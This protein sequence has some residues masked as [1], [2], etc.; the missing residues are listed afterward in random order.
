MAAHQQL[1]SFPAC[2]VVLKPAVP[3]AFHDFAPCPHPTLHALGPCSMQRLSR[4]FNAPA[5]ARTSCQQAATTSATI[6]I[7]H[8]HPTHPCPARAYLLPGSRTCRRRRHMVWAG[9]QTVL[10][11]APRQA[12]Q[13]AALAGCL[14]RL[15]RCRRP[16]RRCRRGAH[17]WALHLRG[18]P[19]SQSPWVSLASPPPSCRP[20]RAWCQ[21]QTH[22][23]RSHPQQTSQNCTW[24]KGRGR[25]MGPADTPV[26]MEWMRA[27]NSRRAA[28]MV[29]A[30]TTDDS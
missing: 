21:Q 7:P 19:A 26:S 22:S 8:Y 13:T 17:R 2:C 1:L 12:R 14:R 5:F 10:G 3:A 29:R 4:L 11:Q 20:G 30:R 27:T 25:P 23:Q 15:V 9:C 6:T 24:G 18:V 28:G 16:G